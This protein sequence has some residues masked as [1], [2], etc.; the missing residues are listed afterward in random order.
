MLSATKVTVTKIPASSPTAEDDII[1]C[2]ERDGVAII[3]GMFPKEHVE[4]VRRD[5]A[6][7]FDSDIPDLSGFFPTTTRRANAVFGISRACTDT[8]MHPL[9][10]AV[11]DRLLTSTYYYFRG[12]K[13]FKA[14][15]KPVI[16]ATNGFRI[17]P[18][19]LQQPLHRDDEDYHARPCDR[20]MMVS[21]VIALTR[22]HKDN[23]ATLVI[24][25]SH[26][27]ED[28]DR[29][30]LTEET[31]PAELEP[32]DG[33]IFLGNLYHGGGANITEDEQ[34]EV[35]GVFLMKA[36]YRQVENEY[37]MIPP[38]RCRELKLTPKELRVLGYGTAEPACGLVNYKD[39]MES[40]FGI[41]DDE[42]VKH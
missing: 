38:E 10:L 24:P 15:A 40:I 19:G 35:V 17:I 13:K 11:A 8:M 2:L 14:V 5:L 41:T 4:Q 27:W 39:P 26:L 23:G 18:G 25:G 9:V 22:T 21:C 32:G 3:T 36:F 16:S 42:T 30:P 20:P 6:P 29:A 34:R 28:E 31:V 1:K 7:H 37:L 12:T 33:A